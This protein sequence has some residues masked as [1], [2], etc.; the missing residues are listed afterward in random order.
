M[1]DW[2]FAALTSADRTADRPKRRIGKLEVS[3]NKPRKPIDV[4]KN[5]LTRGLR[6]GK[7]CL[8]A[9]SISFPCPAVAQIVG[10]A[11]F[12]WFYFDMEHSGM[13]VDAIEPICSASK[14]AGVVP[15]AG[16]TGIA[17]FLV[18]R[19][20][21]NGAMGVI[22]PH[23]GDAEETKVVVNACR[24]P[25]EGSRGMLGLGALTEF[26][27]V[28]LNDWVDAMNRE[29]LASVKVESARGVENIDEIAA[30]PGLDAIM[31]GPSDLTTSLGIPGQ[32]EH[33]RFK[34][35]M[36]R[37]AKACER[38]SVAWGPHVGNPEEV[39]H[40]ADRGATFMSCGFD[41]DLLLQTWKDTAQRANELLGGRAIG[42]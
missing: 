28:D 18:S 35:A 14:L 30:V 13:P 24:Y 22:A 7:V 12:S 34:D 29:I 20:L 11:G 27:R 33:A 25:P 1:S 9:L 37:I 15:I 36:D 4:W 41:G 31:V 6:E 23:V 39:K 5:P 3:G 21:D 10:Q 32:F 8:G 17:D 40:W 26:Q 19:P 38:N 16:S 2:S 42:V